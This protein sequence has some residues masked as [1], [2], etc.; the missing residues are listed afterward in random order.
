[1]NSKNNKSESAK[2]GTNGNDL[3]RALNW[4]LSEGIFNDI[5]FHGNVR[6]SA[7]ALV[8]L[9]IFWVW[10]ADPSLVAA[11]D[12]AIRS[13]LEIFGVAPVTSYQG[14]TNVL[15]KYSVE[16]LP[17]LWNRMHAL[18][19][20]TD[21]A[22]FRTGLWLALAVDGSRID[23]PRTVPNEQRFSKPKYARKKSKKI[24]RSRHA[25]RS[26]ANT[27]RRKSH[28]DPQPGRPQMWLTLI[29]HM[30]LQLPWCWKIGPSYSSERGHVLELLESHKFPENTL[31]CGDAGFVGYDFWKTIRNHQ[32]HFMVR[33]GSNVRLLKQLGYVRES[34]GIVYCW[35]DEAAK[36]KQPPLPLRLLRFHDG[37]GE[38]YLVTSVLNEKNLTTKQAGELYRQRWG[39][40]LQFRSLKQTFDR[41]KIRCRTPDCAEIELHWSL[42][43]LWI[44]QLLA[45]K[46]RTTWGE[47]DESTSVAAAV[48]IIRNMMSHPSATRTPAQALG[49]QLADA[50]TDSYQRK[51]RKKSRNYPRRKEEPSAGKPQ[52]QMATAAHRRKLNDI[53]QLSAAA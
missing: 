47:P 2:V 29:W 50:T 41:S 6:W 22:R 1:M 4:V 52:I 42:M 53:N 32:F 13:N 11:A 46:E 18:M 44:I 9:A 39:I 14:L 20:R 51:S 8:Q 35:P 36:K 19:E 12:A 28:Y 27:S 40:E 16:L 30:G 5:A 37:R 49:K 3:K 31:F 15:K 23:V 25:N 7:V 26:R 38:I 48:R 43:G 24:K 33:V 34:R 21:E 45:L 17:R 10:A